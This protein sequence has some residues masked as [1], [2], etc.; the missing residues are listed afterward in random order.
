M[1]KP[2]RSTPKWKQLSGQSEETEPAFGTGFGF[3]PVFHSTSFSVFEL[4]LW[5][6]IR[7]VE[8]KNN[9]TVINC[10][11]KQAPST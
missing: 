4:I 5:S 9:N 1:R 10:C 8:K 11:N 2:M 3:V 6:E 7:P